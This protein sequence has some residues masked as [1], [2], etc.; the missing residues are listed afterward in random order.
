[1]FRVRINGE[2]EG[3][4]DRWPTLKE[5]QHFVGGFVEHVRVLTSDGEEIH[6]LVNEDG[7]RIGLPLNRV[8]TL[9]YGAPIVGNAWIWYGP[10]PADA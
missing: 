3:A 2:A 9:L 6:M 10:L 1:M 5:M 8:A 7:L 4:G